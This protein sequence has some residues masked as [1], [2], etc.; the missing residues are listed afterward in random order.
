MTDEKYTDDI[1]Q[2]IIEPERR[3]KEYNGDVRCVTSYE[4]LDIL[5]A[6]KATTDVVRLRSGLPRLDSLLTSF[7]GGELTVISGFTKHGKTLFAQTL[8]QNFSDESHKALWFSFEIPA[9]QFLKQFD[10][11]LPLFILPLELRI[12]DA[13]WLRDRIYE[14]LLKHDI[15]AV[16]IDNTHN[17]LNLTAGDLTHRVDE[18]VK[19]LKSLAMEFNIAVF[20]LHHTMKQKY[21]SLDQTGSHLLR[22][23]SMIAQTADTIIFVIREQADLVNNPGNNVAWLKITENRKNG[24]FNEYVKLIKIGKFFKEVKN[25]QEHK[26]AYEPT[27]RS[28]R[29]ADNHPRKDTDG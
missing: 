15:K 22:D 25:E 11:P 29:R 10:D 7:D 5:H 4:M 20:L 1:I 28:H 21:E 14:A 16:F 18:F 2:K 9:E 3:L 17:I 27:R 26:A 8:T 23:S 12:N 19:Q 6:R 24:V 13:R